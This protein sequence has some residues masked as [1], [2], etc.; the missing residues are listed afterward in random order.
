[1]VRIRRTKIIKEENILDD[2]SIKNAIFCEY[3]FVKQLDSILNLQIFPNAVS[4][5]YENL[6]SLFKL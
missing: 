5:N 1:M 6:M 3:E 4:N 2:Q